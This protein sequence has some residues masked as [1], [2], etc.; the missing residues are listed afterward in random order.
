MWCSARQG[1]TLAS[2]NF[3]II[4]NACAASTGFQGT[5]PPFLAW[6]KIDHLYHNEPDARGLYK[7]YL[8]HFFP[9]YYDLRDKCVSPI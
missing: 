7:K 9:C 3:S 2:D 8:Q 6:E 4:K 1:D 5:A